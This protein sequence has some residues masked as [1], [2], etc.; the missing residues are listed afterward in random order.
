MMGRMWI[1]QAWFGLMEF[2]GMCAK[3]SRPFISFEL[4]D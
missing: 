4:I 3:E 1:K 2:K